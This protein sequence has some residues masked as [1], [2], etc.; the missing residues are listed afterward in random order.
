MRQRSGR[1][2][3][4]IV[5]V[6]L[7]MAAFAP[8]ADLTKATSDAEGRK[9]AAESGARTIRAKAVQVDGP[10]ELYMASASAHNAWLDAT[11]ALIDKGGSDTGQ[12]S[13][14]SDAAGKAAAALVKWVAG[15]NAALGEPVLSGKTA[16]SV[17]ARIRQDL[18][19]ISAETARRQRGATS[20]KK[21]QAASD[22]SNRLRWKGWSEL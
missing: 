16:D 22:L 6:I 17:E 4:S 13:A 11:K 12:D 21:S 2:V 19:D 3:A 10:R 9:K 14:V 7:V 1:T 15:R 5:F 20:D 8:A 18:V